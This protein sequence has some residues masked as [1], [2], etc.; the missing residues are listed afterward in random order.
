MNNVERK[1]RFLSTAQAACEYGWPKGGLK[2]L[3]CDRARNGLQAA[4]VRVG[5]KLLIDCD[6]FEK[7]L[8]R[9]KE[10][11]TQ[12]DSFEKRVTAADPLLNKGG[13]NEKRR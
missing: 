5:R 11:L 8:E 1:K 2:A 10:G 9:H 12:S 3:L 4:T 7:W 6:E 13:E